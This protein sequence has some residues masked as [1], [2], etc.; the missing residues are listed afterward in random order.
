MPD[1][2]YDALAAALAEHQT[3]ASIM[4]GWSRR[5]GKDSDR[6][7]G[8][9]CSCGAESPDAFKVDLTGDEAEAARFRHVAE[10]VL[11]PGA[12]Q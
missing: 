2:D 1:A 6:R 12:D 10:R 3:R 5:N 9:F 8:W 4:G 7:Y 11:S